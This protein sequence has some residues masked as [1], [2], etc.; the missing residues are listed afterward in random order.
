MPQFVHVA[1][2]LPGQKDEFL[3]NVK[4]GFEMGAPGLKSLGLTRITS[5]H[6][7][8]ANSGSGGLLITIYEAN[9][10]SVIEALYKNAAVVE[11]EKRNHGKLV[12]EHDHELVA[13]NTPFLDL[14]LR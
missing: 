5:F 10:A 8:E 9:D 1:R 13:T 3:A 12:A 14:D 11:G 2:I 6:S 7:A 4:N